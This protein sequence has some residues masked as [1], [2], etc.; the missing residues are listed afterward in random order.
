MTNG[1]EITCYFFGILHSIN[2]IICQYLKVVFG[3]I[4][5]RISK[6]KLVLYGFFEHGKERSWL[7]NIHSHM[8]IYIYVHVSM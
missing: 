7:L 5:V 8:Y 4:S 6:S 3:A 2:G 1:D